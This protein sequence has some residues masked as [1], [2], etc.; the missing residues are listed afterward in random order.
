MQHKSGNTEVSVESRGK[1]GLC[2]FTTK[3]ASPY[4]QHNPPTPVQSQ[5]CWIHVS[6]NSG[7]VLWHIAVFMLQIF[8]LEPNQSVDEWFHCA[9]KALAGSMCARLK[10]ICQRIS[11]PRS[12]LST[13]AES[14][15]KWLVGFYTCTS[16]S[17]LESDWTSFL[18]VAMVRANPGR[19]RFWGVFCLKLKRKLDFSPVFTFL[20]FSCCCCLITCYTK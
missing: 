6:E 14:V 5:R 3:W 18:S 15:L 9:A 2:W 7:G 10:Q 17:C 16:L 19:W 4:L 8:S 12:R 20:S 1:C 11:A 13:G